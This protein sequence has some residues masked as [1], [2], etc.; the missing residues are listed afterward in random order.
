MKYVLTVVSQTMV[1][2]WIID[3][4]LRY[5]QTHATRRK[6]VPQTL[7]GHATCVVAVAIDLSSPSK[8]LI[9]L[10]TSNSRGYQTNRDASVV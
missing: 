1:G 3:I 7:H 2:L 9:L 4:V 8:L 10:V 5:D 6:H